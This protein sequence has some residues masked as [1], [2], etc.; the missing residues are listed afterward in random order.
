MSPG[1]Q[2][3]SQAVSP[4]ERLD[5]IDPVTS[6]MGTVCQKYPASTRVWD[7][8]KLLRLSLTPMVCA[9]KLQASVDDLKTH[10]YAANWTVNVRA[11]DLATGK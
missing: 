8:D 1:P 4:P 7:Y 3:A 2:H 11:L 9:K 10:F 5:N 6:V